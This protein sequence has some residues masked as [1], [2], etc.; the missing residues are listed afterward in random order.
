MKKK[1]FAILLVTLAVLT[2]FAG[3]SNKKS[4]DT[5]AVQDMVKAPS[6]WIVSDVEFSACSY[7]VTDLDQNGKPEI[8]AD[9]YAADTKTVTSKIYITDEDG[10]ISEC[11]RKTAGQSFEKAY[12]DE[13]VRYGNTCYYDAENNIYYY[14]YTKV[15][16][17]SRFEQYKQFISFS[18]N[19]D[20]V[21][22]E[23]LATEIELYNE[24][25]DDVEYTYTDGKGNPTDEEGYDNAAKNRYSDLQ[26]KKV[27]FG[28]FKG[29]TMEQNEKLKSM[30]KAELEDLLANSFN[31]FVIS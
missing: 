12:F 18:L 9:Y 22:E 30:S 21:T 14:N 15:T 26:E 11:E 31:S 13:T 10:N 19:G 2:V 17:I 3:C 20:V 1:L 6:E 27:S 25:I 29:Y 7:G 8:I 4:N 5:Q 23:L 16:R 28:G 24:E